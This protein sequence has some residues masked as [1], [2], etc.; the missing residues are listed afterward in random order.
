MERLNWPVGG[1]VGPPRRCVGPGRGER[2]CPTR[3]PER[4]RSPAPGRRPRGPSPRPRRRRVARRARRVTPPVLD[5]AVELNGDGCLLKE[6]V[7][8]GEKGSGLDAEL[9]DWVVSD[10]PQCPAEP[11][12]ARRLGPSI[13]M[14]KHRS[15]GHRTWAG[16]SGARLGELVNADQPSVQ[17][18]ICS[19]QPGTHWWTVRPLRRRESVSS[20]RS[21]GPGAG[22]RRRQG[23][24]VAPGHC[25][26]LPPLVRRPPAPRPRSARRAAVA[27][28]PTGP[29]HPAWTWQTTDSTNRAPDG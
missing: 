24:R 3:S 25:D 2:P 18:G 19:D 8:H 1:S 23:G 26:G 28:V 16:H 17:R 15:N 4:V 29:R 6:E 5:E 20:T 21:G 7:D 22:P 13:G 12:L 9:G 11:R 14:T 10:Q 27:G